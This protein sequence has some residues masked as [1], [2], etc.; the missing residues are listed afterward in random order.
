M[1]SKVS[2]R[3]VVGGA[4]ATL[5]AAQ[6]VSESAGVYGRWSPA[7]LQAANEES[8]RLVREAWRRLDARGASC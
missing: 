3:A 5:T 6:P 4:S 8:E 1:R 7:E 2:R